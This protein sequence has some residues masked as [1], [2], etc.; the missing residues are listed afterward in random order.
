MKKSLYY[1]YAYGDKPDCIIELYT[2]IPS[3]QNLARSFE[4][5]M[6]ITPDYGKSKL[7]LRISPLYD[8]KEVLSELE[9]AIKQ[10]IIDNP[11]EEQFY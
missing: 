1:L 11:P 10:N 6:Q 7:S 2:D 9:K 3:I 5:I 4:G 8:E